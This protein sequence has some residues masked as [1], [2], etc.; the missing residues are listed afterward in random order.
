MKRKSVHQTK[1]L[2]QFKCQMPLQVSHITRSH[3]SLSLTPVFSIILHEYN[4][5]KRLICLSMYVLIRFKA[6]C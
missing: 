3:L 2:V 4:D 5:Q 6:I 1:G